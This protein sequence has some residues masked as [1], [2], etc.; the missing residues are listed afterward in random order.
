MVSLCL[1]KQ[2]QDDKWDKKQKQFFHRS[3]IKA[4]ELH[5]ETEQFKSDDH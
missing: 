5:D 1:E 3:H 2:K 4:Y